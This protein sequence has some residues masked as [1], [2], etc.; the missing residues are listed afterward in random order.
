MGGGGRFG[1]GMVDEEM[2]LDVGMKMGQTRAI[3]RSEVTA[4]RK[5]Q[6]PFEGLL[7][8]LFPPN[9]EQYCVNAQS[10]TYQKRGFSNLFPFELGDFYCS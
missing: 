5:R 2:E 3:R 7:P 8:H 4:S 6:S 1:E 10:T 9:F